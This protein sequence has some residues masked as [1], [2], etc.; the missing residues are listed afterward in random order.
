[1]ANT[2]TSLSGYKIHGIPM[3]GSQLKITQQKYTDISFQKHLKGKEGN[4][5]GTCLSSFMSMT[6]II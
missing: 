3:T 1:M 5:K 4:S 6:Q 2:G